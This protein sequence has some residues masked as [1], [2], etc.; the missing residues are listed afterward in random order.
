MKRTIGFFMTLAM[1][2]ALLPGV[3]AAAAGETACDT[4]DGTYPAEYVFPGAGTPEDPY[5]IDSAAALAYLSASTNG[6][7]TWADTYFRMTVDIDMAN[8]P[9]I[10]I[11][12]MTGTT[13]IT[14]FSGVF[15]G[16]YHKIE[17][18]ALADRNSEQIIYNVN[19]LFGEIQNAV[20]R[21]IGIQSGAISVSGARVGAIVG[22]ACGSNT[23]ENCYNLANITVVAGNTTQSNVGGICGVTTEAGTARI[24]KNCWNA[25]DISITVANNQQFRDGG[26]I[27]SSTGVTLYLT[28]CVNTGDVTVTELGENAGS[29][30]SNNRSI[31]GV[32]GASMDAPILVDCGNAGTVAYSGPGTLVTAAAN[33]GYYI[34]SLIGRFGGN[35]NTCYTNGA[36]NNVGVLNTAYM[37]LLVG[38]V[39][40]TTDT[41]NNYKWI[42]AVESVSVQPAYGNFLAYEAQVLTLTDE[43]KPAAYLQWTAA[44]AGGRQKVRAI[45]CADE[46]YLQ[47][48]ED[49]AITLTFTLTDGETRTAVVPM[50]Q[51]TAYRS[52]YAANQL[53]AAADGCVLL[54]VVVSNVPAGGWSSASLSTTVQGTENAVAAYTV[55]GSVSYSND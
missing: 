2:C 31:G 49:I 37:K 47:E 22:Y 13:G 17:N 19:G 42:D 1:L 46:R 25:G 51:L 20:I 50:S 12:A 38:S 27:G 28:N 39:A 30:S 21:N 3:P 52:V 15:D 54:G 6:G 9:W 35:S 4:W 23:V 5:L 24:F 29:Q 36:K 45:I 41:T 16:G 43:N 10:G 11:G 8:Q 48:I 7:N 44:D 34:G 55:S 18:F 26:I 53:C 33:G 14:V 40:D 32:I